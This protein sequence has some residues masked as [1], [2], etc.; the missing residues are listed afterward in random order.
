MQL[1]VILGKG[2]IPFYLINLYAHSGHGAEK[3]ALRAELF[4]VAAQAIQP[5][6]QSPCFIVGDFNADPTPHPD[7]QTLIGQGWVDLGE[8]WAAYQDLDPDPTYHHGETHTRI[9]LIWANELAARSI[10][11][12][13]VLDGSGL[14]PHS[15]VAVTFQYRTWMEPIRKWP[16]AVNPQIPNQIIPCTQEELTLWDAF[17]ETYISSPNSTEWWEA[18]TRTAELSLLQH[19][20]PDKP[21]LGRGTALTPVT[22][23][24]LTR[25]TLGGG[26]LAI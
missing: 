3:E 25:K 9:D 7:F 17:K 16:K 10:V 20:A 4:H 12:F 15:P 13:Q 6:L 14:A 24:P 23:P 11:Q 26:R 1:M 18:W 22:L 19:A 21:F 2:G 5:Y 8:A